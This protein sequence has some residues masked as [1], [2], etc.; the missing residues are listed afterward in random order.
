MPDLLGIARNRAT[1]KLRSF[2]KNSPRSTTTQSH[3]EDKA[4]QLHCKAPV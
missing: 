1:L 3:N 4:E 2:E